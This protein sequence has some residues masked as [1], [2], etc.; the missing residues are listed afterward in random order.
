MFRIKTILF[1][2]IIQIPVL[3]ADNKPTQDSTATAEEMS[4]IS[5]DPVIAMLDSMISMSYFV[6]QQPFYEISS[7]NPFNFDLEDI[8][9]YSDSIVSAK[10][11]VLNGTTPFDFVYNGQVQKYIDFYAYRR[12]GSVSNMLG[13]GRLYFPLFEE[14]LDRYNLPVELK[15]LAIVE[16]ALNPVAV[17]RAGAV[18]LWQFMPATGRIYGLNPGHSVDDRR[19]PYKSTEAACRH[20]IDLYNRFGDW[21]LVLAAYNAGSG[22]VSRAI[23]RAGGETDYWKVQ[24]YLPRETQNYVPAFIAI[25]YVM[26]NHKD[27]NLFPE[28]PPFDYYELDTLTVRGFL[29]L[30]YLS[31]KLAIERENLGFLNPALKNGNIYA[32]PTEPWYLIL[33][34]SFVGTF[35]ANAE[36]FYKE[37][38]E[39]SKSQQTAQTSSGKIHVVRRGESLGVIAKRYRVS[40]SALKS[41]NNLKSNMIHPGQRLIIP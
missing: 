29:T 25:S 4:Y 16:S 1:F 18:G 35:L 30:D 5:D 19:D 40:V 22:N 32:S 31:E 39:L 26:N 41:K 3:F 10:L 14:M 33:P 23:R 24:P 38:E 8:P 6:R 15:Y 20:F 11:E 37:M 2:L 36:L 7:D 34:R 21:N 13:L 28:N 12:R 17:S 9:Y 27:Y